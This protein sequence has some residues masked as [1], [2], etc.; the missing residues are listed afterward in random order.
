M[1]L[2][3]VQLDLID[4]H[5]HLDDDRFDADRDQVMQRAAAQGIRQLIIPATIASRW[6]K[7]KNVARAYP[8]VYA[9][10][11]LHPMFM[12]DHQ[13]QHVAQLDQWLGS[14]QAVAVG[15]C[16]LDFYQGHQDQPQQLELLRGQFSVAL[17]HRLPVIIHARKSLDIIL[18][19]IRRSGL[20]CGV[21]HSFSGSLQQAQ[22]LLE[23]GFKI[24]LAATV[25]YQRARKLQQ[26][27]RQIDISGLLIESDAPDQAGELH[28]GQRNEPAFII[29]HLKVMAQ[30]REMSIDAL[31]TQLTHNCRELFALTEPEPVESEH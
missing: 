19:E 5:C 21:I 26:V 31:A 13:A 23:L 3:E 16:G 30:L 22:Q 18:H 11:G 20:R 1:S 2:T 24:S 12:S 7:V 10:Y 17:N 4:S 8:G 29:D 6:N 28:R 25:G 27:T 14:E 9:S 15:E